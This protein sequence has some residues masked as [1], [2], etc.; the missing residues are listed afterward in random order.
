MGGGDDEPGGLNARGFVAVFVS[1]GY[2]VVTDE[3]I[4][5]NE[6]L[7]AVRGIGQAL[8]VPDHRG[9]EYH[10][11]RRRAVKTEAGAGELGAVFQFKNDSLFPGLV[12]V[13]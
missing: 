6:Y 12:T 7:S 3:G 4:G 13:E 5:E 10:L 8:D 1:G 9:V 2:A 11:A